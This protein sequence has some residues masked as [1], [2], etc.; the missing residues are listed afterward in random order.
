MGFSSG[1]PR[2]TGIMLGQA[3]CDTCGQS[4]VEFV[5][6]VLKDVDAINGRHPAE[7]FG[8]GGGI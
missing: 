2:T 5:G 7:G 1:P 6:A 8:C 3:L 4:D